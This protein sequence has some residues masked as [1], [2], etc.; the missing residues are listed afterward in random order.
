M[1]KTTPRTA[2]VTGASAGIGAAFA[3]ALA[4][5]G[6]DLI[7]TARR[8]DR[9]E[10]LAAEIRQAHGSR[11]LVVPA[12]LADREAPDALMAAVEEAGL[13]VDILVNNA[14]YGVRGHYLVSPW[15]VHA[16]FIQVLATAVAHVTHRVL[17]GMVERDYGRIINVASV[18]GLL[19]GSAGHTL[20]AAAKAFL[21]KFS[22]SLDLELEGRNIHVQALCPGFTYSEFHDVNGSRAEVS[23]YPTYMWM[24]AEDV[25][26]RSLAAVMAGK[27]P[28]LVTGRFYQWITG[29]SKV[30][31]S[32]MQRGLARRRIRSAEA[33]RRNQGGT[34]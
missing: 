20:Y 12:D 16:E 17:P 28:V 1:T 18:A 22:E 29:L 30:L 14:G 33:F 32:G 5:Q 10:A 26:D 25:V 3:R 15:E 4:Q 34:G 23:T 27:G 2:L 13:T 21:I 11:I 24:T 6:H 8:A 7:L 31:P 19:P 9:L